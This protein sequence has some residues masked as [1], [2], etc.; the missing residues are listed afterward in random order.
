MI[1]AIQSAFFHRDFHYFF[2]GPE[3]TTVLRARMSMT[4]FSCVC[5][6]KIRLGKNL[7]RLVFLLR[8]HTNLISRLHQLAY[9]I[10]CFVH[11]KIKQQTII[12]MHGYPRGSGFKQ[13][14]FAKTTDNKAFKLIIYCL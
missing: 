7:G 11:R 9:L 2:V 10:K 1:S 3:N 12:V 14:D 4:L 13:I 5:E 8:V 6:S